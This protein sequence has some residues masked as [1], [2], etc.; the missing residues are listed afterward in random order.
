MYDLPD[1]L[2][3]YV[4]QSEEIEKLRREVNGLK[5]Q[6]QRLEIVSERDFR[7]ESVHKPRLENLSPSRQAGSERSSAIEELFRIIS[8]APSERVDRIIDDIRNGVPL[9]AIIRSVKIYRDDDITDDSG[10]YNFSERGMR[11][12]GEIPCRPRIT[13]LTPLRVVIQATK[14]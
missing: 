14:R 8:S 12:L 2:R 5:Q 10:V 1:G 7:R 3:G 4:S 13:R 9:S 11:A 6:L